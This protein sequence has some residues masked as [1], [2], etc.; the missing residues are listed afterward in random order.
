MKSPK[1]MTTITT[2]S[3]PLEAYLQENYEYTPF[4]GQCTG[5]TGFCRLFP[6]EN[7]EGYCAYFATAM[8]VLAVRRYSNP[9]CTGIRRPAE[10]KGEDGTY[11]VRNREVHSGRKPILEGIGWIQFELTPARSELL[12]AD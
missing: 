8:A 10:R 3:R 5:G 7:K 1:A 2:S 11:A 4:P 12:Y 6:F 9:V